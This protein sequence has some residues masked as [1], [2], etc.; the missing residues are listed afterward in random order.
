MRLAIFDFDG[1]ISSEDSFRGFIIYYCGYLSFIIGSIILSPIYFLYWFKII[2]NNSMKERV[3]GYYFKNEM[4][5]NFEREC[6]S[7]SINEIPKMI[8]KKAKERIDWHLSNGD[9]VIV[10]SASINS[11]LKVWCERN[12]LGLI[13]TEL[14]IK[15]G[16]ISGKL[17]G[18]NC[19]GAEKVRRIKKDINMDDFEC[20]YAY[21]DSRGDKEILELATESHFK[22]FRD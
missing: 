14:D 7:Y 9:K 12:K 20:I 3:I 5:E 16:K 13:A 17:K 10:V 6:L 4:E 19:F 1:T 21:G 18:K 15:D 22:P 8:R 11:W 2:S